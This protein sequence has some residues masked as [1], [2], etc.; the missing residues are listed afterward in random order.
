MPGVRAVTDTVHY[1]YH[2]QLPVRQ[3]VLETAKTN[4]SPQSGLMP[5]IT[6]KEEDGLAASQP[7]ISTATT[8]S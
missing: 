4:Y 5:S 1:K 3:H 6:G 7:F 2:W 8:V